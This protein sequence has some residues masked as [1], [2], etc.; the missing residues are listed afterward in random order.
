[1]YLCV[2]FSEQMDLPPASSP[3]WLG[4]PGFVSS[5][6]FLT[7]SS[8]QTSGH[9][10]LKGQ[11]AQVSAA[12]MTG[13]QGRKLSRLSTLSEQKQVSSNHE[14]LR[15]GARQKDIYLPQIG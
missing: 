3:H 9:W 2:S 8:T 15:Q 6:N 14:Q 13:K 4:V 5:G 11:L 1:M 7:E 12:T 10:S